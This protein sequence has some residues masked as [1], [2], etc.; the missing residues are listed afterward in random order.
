[1]FSL[2]SVRFF[3]YF[4]HWGRNFPTVI[5]SFTNIGILEAAPQGAVIVSYQSLAIRREIFPAYSFDRSLPKNF[6]NVGWQDHYQTGLYLDRLWQALVLQNILESGIGTMLLK[7][8]LNKLEIE[9]K[10]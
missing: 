4:E 8:R 3:H 6:T 2:G 1:M 7:G 10:G 5:F 9:G